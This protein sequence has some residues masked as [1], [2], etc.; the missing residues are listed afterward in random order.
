MDLSIHLTTDNQVKLPIE[1]KIGLT[2]VLA[3]II[4]YTGIRF[5]KDLPI[6]G[7]APIYHT[8]LTNSNGLVPGNIVAVNGVGVGSITEVQL[9][10]TGA[11]ISFSVQDD[12]IL[13]EGTIASAGGSGFMSTVQLD[14]SLGPPDA[15][16]YEPGSLIP[17]SVQSDI[18]AD[19]ANR[20]PSVLNRVDTV[21]AG[22]SQAISAATELLAGPEGQMQQTLTS[23]RSSAE[24]FHSVL[25]AEQGSLQSV[26]QGIEDLVN[27]AESFTEDS[28]GATAAELNAVIEQ[29]SNN[30]DILETTTNELNT[31]ISSINQGQGTLGKL[32]T[33]DSLYFELQGATAALRRILETFEEDPRQYLEHLKLIDF[34]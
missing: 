30:L 5:F 11:Y 21:L 6:F 1:L 20:T 3:G 8:E 2:V 18:L 22:S 25:L 16:A 9:T 34:F 7:Q 4:F 29:L 15:P 17:S 24:A 31:L 23:I 14:L 32:A 27:T 12:V 28:L 19:I 33:D 26:L 10:L 13:T